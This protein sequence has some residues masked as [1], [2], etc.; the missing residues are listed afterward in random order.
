MLWGQLLFE[1]LMHL[2]R[3]TTLCTYHV[4]MTR[5]GLEIY[6]EYI[7]VHVLAY[8]FLTHALIDR[9]SVILAWCLMF[10]RLHWRNIYMHVHQYSCKYTSANKNLIHT[11]IKDKAFECEYKNLYKCNFRTANSYMYI[12]IY[13]YTYVCLYIQIFE[14]L[15][16]R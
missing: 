3:C 15:H 14:Y 16:E 5:A 10:A 1:H 6:I 12:H 11:D 8:T 2:T 7:D 13:I 9:E 4:Y